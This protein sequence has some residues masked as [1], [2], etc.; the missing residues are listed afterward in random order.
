MSKLPNAC[1]P[2]HGRCKVG[3][4]FIAALLSGLGA[5]I[6]FPQTFDPAWSIAL[7][8]LDPGQTNIDEVL[9]RVTGTRR[10]AGNSMQLLPDGESSFQAMIALVESAEHHINAGTWAFDGRDAEQ[11]PEVRAFVELVEAKVR[12]GVEINIIIDPVVQR[13]W[14][15]GAQLRELE[16]VGVNV[17][18]YSAPTDELPLNDLMHRQHKKLVIVDGRQAITGDINFGVRYVGHETWRSTNVLLNGPIVTTMQRSFL[19]DW[20]IL[21][22]QIDD[23]SRFLPTIAPTGDLAVRAVDQR[24]TEDDFSINAAVLVALRFAR[25]RVD[26]EA[27]YFNPSDWLADELLATA[28]RGVDVRIL[29]NAEISQNQPFSYQATA[30]WF[31]P[32]LAGGV[33][34]FLWSQPNSTMHSKT[35]VVDNQ[36]AMLSTH[37]SNIRSIMWD[38]ETAVIF[39]DETA[40]QQ[41]REMTEEGF[42]HPCVLEI[43]LEWLGARSLG[44]RLLWEFVH[45]LGWIL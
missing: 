8:D 37:N 35:M 28:A 30:Y 11:P 26:I 29:A 32:M 40:V 34:I 39:T 2:S 15:T 45:G 9:D 31:E 18:P 10:D 20:Q 12:A 24:P 23:E 44:E 33:R 14:S 5:C 17:R 13:L 43:D 22:D 19:R 6:D 38:T 4:A 41:V 27:P 7:E 42:N 16:G 3:V 1:Y 36:F 21:G 25:E